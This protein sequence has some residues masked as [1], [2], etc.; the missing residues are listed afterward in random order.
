MRKFIK[1]IYQ[2]VVT[3]AMAL[4][5]A[6]VCIQFNVGYWA[7]PIVAFFGCAMLGALLSGL[8]DVNTKRTTRYESIKHRKGL[9]EA[10]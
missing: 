5:G 4:I 9:Q 1:S 10:A 7:A 8:I 3:M 2:V 6:V